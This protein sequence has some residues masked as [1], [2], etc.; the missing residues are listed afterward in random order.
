M[1]STTLRHVRDQILEPMVL[2]LCRGES[3]VDSLT[4]DLLAVIAIRVRSL[5]DPNKRDAYIRKTAKCEILKHYSR[6]A[7]SKIRCLGPDG[8]TAMPDSRSPSPL[9]LVCQREEIEALEQAV[10]QLN[11]F[12]T[13]TLSTYDTLS[14]Q[15]RDVAQ[16]HGVTESRV[17]Q[18]RG[19]IVRK[20]RLAFK[21]AG[22]M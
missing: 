17:Y 15:V 8:F 19:E 2:R 5:R 1:N 4:D 16:R 14:A 22:L 9:Q 18:A 3:D 6:S 13:D 10:G 11:A 21:R 12:E 20:L 7:K